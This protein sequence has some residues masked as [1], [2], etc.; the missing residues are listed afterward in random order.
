MPCSKFH[1]CL[2][3][4]SPSCPAIPF[5]QKF[6]IFYYNFLNFNQ[7]Y[8]QFSSKIS[9]IFFKSSLIFKYSQFSSKFSSIFFKKSP[10]FSSK[11]LFNFLQKFSCLLQKFASIFSKSS[12]QFSSK[13]LLDFP[14]KFSSIF[15]KSS[16]QFSPKVLLNFLQKLSI[17][18]NF[19]KLPPVPKM[20]NFHANIFLQFEDTV[21]R[22][23]LKIGV[24][25]NRAKEN[26]FKNSNFFVLGNTT[27]QCYQTMVA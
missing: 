21:H 16:P 5:L 10:R 7:I 6:L 17:F 22:F 20:G 3:H 1:F 11:V 27:W 14:Q 8:F 15:S 23:S 12:P 9:S 18:F 26:R 19:F 13:N 4:F 25:K 2:A 24:Q